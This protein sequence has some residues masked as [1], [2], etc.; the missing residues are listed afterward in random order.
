MRIHGHVVEVE[1][2]PACQRWGANQF[3]V[4]SEQ[5]A[6]LGIDDALAILRF[7]HELVVVILINDG[8]LVHGRQSGSLNSLNT[9][10]DEWK[11]GFGIHR[12]VVGKALIPQP[13]G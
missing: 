5:A 2:A 4:S 13:C 3:P 8:D 7:D 6:L 10:L 12:L 9:E 1:V 11:S